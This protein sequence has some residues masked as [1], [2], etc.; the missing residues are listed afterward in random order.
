MVELF[1]EHSKLSKAPFAYDGLVGDISF[2]RTNVPGESYSHPVVKIL[3]G[4][5]VVLEIHK[6]KDDA[7]RTKVYV[8][9]YSDRLDSYMDALLEATVS[10]GRANNARVGE[11]NRR[12]REQR[13]REEGRWQVS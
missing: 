7:P 4:Q 11:D 9:A 2:G 10:L 6:S 13:L 12:R 1:V 5:V 3:D 8:A